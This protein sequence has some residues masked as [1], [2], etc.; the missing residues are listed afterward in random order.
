MR[1]PL[2][3]G[4]FAR[5]LATLAFL[6]ACGLPLADGPDTDPRPTPPPTTSPLPQ[7][8]PGAAAQSPLRAEYARIEARRVAAG[9]LRTDGG[10]PDTPFTAAILTE[11]FIKIALF[12]EYVFTGNRVIARPTPSTLRR[13]QTPVRMN[14]AF[15]ASV[16]T[17]DQS[18]D[19]AQ[20]AAYAARLSDLTGHSVSLLPEGRAETANFHVLTLSETE[21]LAIGP[22]LRRLLP[23]IPDTSV[24]LITG[25]PRDTFCMVLAFSRGSADVYTD[26]VAVI[27]AE[28]PDLTRVACYHEELAQGMGL[29]NDSPQARPSI[30]NDGKEF[31]RL[32]THDEMLLQ[33]LY[34]AR[35][36]PGMR[37]PEARP[38][39]GQLARELI[40]GES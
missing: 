16:P 25:M 31:G 35:L 12:D 2:K 39:V 27:R 13:W 6:S 23:G 24:G 20:V 15:G 40:G 5:L 11:N 21:R 37:E 33:I 36:T 1:L 14:L 30:F 22:E 32:T 4:A 19:R 26:A 7:P 28:H 9:L 3:R 8:N 18:A 38:I 34:S 17:E 10:G 29:P